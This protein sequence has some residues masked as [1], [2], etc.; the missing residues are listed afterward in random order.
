MCWITDLMVERFLLHAV[1]LRF[2]SVKQLVSL[3]LGG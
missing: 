1:P 2:Y 3:F